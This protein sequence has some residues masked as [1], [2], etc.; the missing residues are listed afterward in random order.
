MIGRI[1]ALL[2]Q[3]EAPMLTREIA[4]ELHCTPENARQ[5][6]VH[7]VGLKENRQ[8]RIGQWQQSGTRWMALYQLGNGGNRARPKALTKAD[9]HRNR[10][11]DPV[12]HAR[13]LAYRRNWRRRKQGQAPLIV[14]APWFAA[15]ATSQGGAHGR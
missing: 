8:I 7:L 11:A 5:Y 12:A 13:E 9:L 15:I 1:V 14:P 10:M 6:L 4:A 2:G 3:V